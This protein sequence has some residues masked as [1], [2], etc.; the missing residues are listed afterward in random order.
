VYVKAR[1]ISTAVGADPY[2]HLM[3]DQEVE[4]MANAER[5][6]AARRLK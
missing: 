6:I 2:T 4:I 3:A 5:Y 1:R